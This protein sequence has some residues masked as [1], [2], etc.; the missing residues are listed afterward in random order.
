MCQKSHIN[1]HLTIGRVNYIFNLYAVDYLLFKFYFGTCYFHS[2]QMYKNKRSQK[3]DGR[4]SA[5]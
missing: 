2:S 5:K 3:N 1:C 4:S